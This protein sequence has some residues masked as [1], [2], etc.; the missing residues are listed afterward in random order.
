[1]MRQDMNW[2]KIC[3]IIIC[4]KE[5]VEGKYKELSKFNKVIFKSIPY[6]KI[7]EQTLQQRRYSDGK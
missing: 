5:F 7:F 3:S 1:M 4:N 6:G 2:E